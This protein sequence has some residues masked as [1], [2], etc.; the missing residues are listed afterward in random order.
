MASGTLP[1]NQPTWMILTGCGFSAGGSI[2][3]ASRCLGDEILNAGVRV[4]A[5]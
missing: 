3:T 1:K 2:S 4:C 5:R